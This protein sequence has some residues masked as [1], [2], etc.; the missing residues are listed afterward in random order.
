[1][2]GILTRNRIWYAVLTV[3]APHRR[4]LRNAADTTEP[5]PAPDADP[6]P[7]SIVRYDLDYESPAAAIV[8][9]RIPIN[10]CGFVHGANFS[11]A[12]SV[13]QGCAA[14]RDLPPE[15]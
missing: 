6:L 1:M 14:P 8:S 3:V 11:N 10:L 12:G 9:T 4:M 2:V 15:I 7:S 13:V 5:E